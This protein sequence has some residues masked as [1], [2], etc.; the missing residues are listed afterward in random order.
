[1]L[2]RFWVALLAWIWGLAA[3]TR[4][5]ASTPFPTLV[6]P[7]TPT[8]IFWTPVPAASPTLPKHTLEDPAEDY[9][10]CTTRQPVLPGQVRWNPRFRLDIQRVTW[11]VDS[12]SAVQWP[13]PLCVVRWDI[14]LYPPQTEGTL[15]YG[16][17]HVQGEAETALRVHF[18]L[19]PERSA[20]QPQWRMH[21]QTSHL[22]QHQPLPVVTRT[23]SGVTVQIPCIW[24]PPSS[25]RVWTWELQLFAP[26]AQNRPLVCDTVEGQVTAQDGL[27]GWSGEAP[28]FLPD[29]LHDAVDV[30]TGRSIAPLPTLAEVQGLRVTRTEDGLTLQV[31]PQNP[32]PTSARYRWQVLMRLHVGAWVP[33][34]AMPTLLCGR[35][36]QGRAGALDPTTLRVVAAEWVQFA[37]NAQGPLCRFILHLPP[38]GCFA[39]SAYYQVDD[40]VSQAQHGD[41]VPMTPLCLQP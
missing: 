18:T 26:E 19:T 12:P 24:L 33:N 29:P 1:M 5:S 30:S 14:A 11:Q 37:V 31:L 22:F 6:L 10:W 38:S 3:C 4:A 40:L 2:R 7:P 25:P 35:T 23:P 8:P 15:L 34:T 13:T 20:F 16:L 41:T 28:V 17:L 39:V 27:R 9:V 36:P 21:G 32:P